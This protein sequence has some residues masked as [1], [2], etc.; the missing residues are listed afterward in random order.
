M[1]IVGRTVHSTF[2]IKLKLS[3]IFLIFIFFPTKSL[4]F[5]SPSDVFTIVFSSKQAKTARP[6]ICL[7]RDPYINSIPCGGFHS[8]FNPFDK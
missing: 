2:S 8:G 5:I 7:G 6:I 1:Y 3:S 4:I